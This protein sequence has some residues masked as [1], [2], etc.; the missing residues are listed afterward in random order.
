[1]IIEIELE[2]LHENLLAQNRIA[3]VTLEQIG[4]LNGLI[5]KGLENKS[6]MMRIKVLKKWAEPAMK[7]LT[8]VTIES[9]KNL[10]LPIASFLIN[11][12]IEPDTSPWELSSYGKELISE[13]EKLVLKEM[14]IEQLE[15]PIGD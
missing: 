14:G 2:A 6:R 9:S 11:L 12:L 15:M 8:G 7:Q 3:Y 1:M 4:G 13:T 10:T 5:R